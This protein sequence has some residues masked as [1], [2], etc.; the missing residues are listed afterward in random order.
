MKTALFCAALLCGGVALAA[1]PGAR[2]PAKG[3]AAKPAAAASSMNSAAE[4]AE[5]HAGDADLSV[6][7]G[8]DQLHLDHRRATLPPPGRAPTGVF[9]GGQRPPMPRTA[10]RKSA[11]WSCWPRSASSPTRWETRARDSAS[12]SRAIGATSC[13]YTPASFSAATLNMRR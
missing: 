10:W 8:L 2:L 4:L 12:R 1:E 3:A 6:D 7:I 13:W 9:A 5:H 11:A